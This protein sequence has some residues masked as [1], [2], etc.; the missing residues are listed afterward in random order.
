MK[1]RKFFPILFFLILLLL[2]GC[3]ASAKADV[4]KA[5]SE[6]LDLLK[7]LDPDT[8]QEYISY[9]DL[10][11]DAAPSS[12]LSPEI[13][14]VFSLFF[15]NFDYKIM[16]VDVDKKAEQASAS[17]R[18]T[19]IDAKSL[20]KDFTSAHLKEEILKNAGSGSKKTASQE[21][22]YLLLGNLLKEKEYEKVESNVTIQLV[23]QEDDW[24]ILKD[25]ALENALV[26]GLLTYLSN[27]EIL[28]PSETVSVYMKTLK[29]MDADQ[30]NAYLNLTSVLNSEDEDEKAIASALVDQMHKCFNYEVV[31]E[32]DQGYTSQVTVAVTSFD[33]A[34]ILDRYQ[35]QLDEYL[36][37]ADAVIEGSEGR[38]AKSQELLLDAINS[39]EATATTEVVLNL[40]NDGV[41]WNVDLGN[42]IGKALF[43][44]LSSDTASSDEDSQEEDESQDSEESEEEDVDSSDEDS[45]EEV[46]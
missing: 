5:V 18:L 40:T 41:D 46:Y 17:V 15:K 14:E 27:P 11:S 25:T 32:S 34:S 22:H 38:Q 3:N 36:A 8:T 33:S 19:T 7:D 23:Q 20:A 44:N 42:E 10:F 31:E 12:S 45:D 29:E 28:T 13:E 1:V 6:E 21:E 39:N 4:K 26:G 16:E 9:Q 24:V 43:G 35:T 30:M 2:A 37:T